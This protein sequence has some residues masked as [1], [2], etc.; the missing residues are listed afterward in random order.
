MY[1]VRCP[2]C[3]KSAIVP[4]AE[5]GLPAVCLACGS[6]YLIPSP[7]PAEPDS[8]P[9]A[10]RTTDDPFDNAGRRFGRTFWVAAACG[11]IVAGLAAVLA[12]RAIPDPVDRATAVRLKEEAETY[13]KE[14]RLAD[15]QRKYHELD[16][17]AGGRRIRDDEVRGLVEQA[18]DD[19]RRLYALLLNQVSRQQQARSGIPATTLPTAPPRQSPPMS[20]AVAEATPEVEEAAPQFESEEVA[21]SPPAAEE[22][23]LSPHTAGP[24]RGSDTS[25]TSPA[26]ST[27]L[28]SVPSENP[29]TAS[30]VAGRRAPIRPMPEQVAGVTDAEIGRSIEKGVEF[31]LSRFDGEKHQLSDA[32]LNSADGGGRNALAVYALMQA[33]QATDDPRLNPRGPLMDGLIKRMK[34]SRLNRGQPQVYATAIRATALALYNRRQDRGTLRADVL[35]LVQSHSRGAYTYAL[36]SRGG[37]QKLWFDNSNSQYGLLGVWAGAEANVEVPT[38]YWIAVDDHW[39]ETQLS[40]GQW[41]YGPG[42]D[43]RLSMTVAGLASLFVTHDRLDAHAAARV[44]GAQPYP[45]ELR[46]GLE[47]LERGDN[48]LD[49]GSSGHWGYTLYGIER[50]GLASGLKYFGRHDWYRVLAAQVVERQSDSGMWSMGAREDDVVETSFALLFLARGRHPILMNK[51]RF[52]GAWA[53]RPRDL[54]NLARFASRQLEREL[55]WQ[56]VPL[57][58][59]KNYADWLDSPI[60]YLASHEPP[61]LAEEDYNNLRAFV[62]AGGLLFTHADGDSAAFSRWVNSELSPKLFPQYEMDAIEP[63]HALWG[64][65]FKIDPKLRP[66]FRG[67]SNGSRLLMVHAPVDVARSWQMRDHSSRRAVFD[68][69]VNLFVYA[70]GKRDLRN[71]L[72]SPHVSD[73]GS[74]ARGA[75]RVARVK[76]PGQWDPEPGAWRRYAKWLARETGTGLDLRPVAIDALE[77][78][79]APIANLTGTVRHNF[80]PE[81]ADAIR[82]YV[83]GGGVLLIDETGGSGDFAEAVQETLL[84]KAFPNVTPVALDPRTHPLFRAGGEESGMSD[85][86]RPKLRPY[87]TERLSAEGRIDATRPLIGFAAGR[88]H[89]V[90]SPLDVTSGLLGTRT[91]GVNGLETDYTEALVKNL[92]F[93]TLDGQQDVTAQ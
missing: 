22:V 46:R 64:L 5:A 77:P 80:R 62:E 74:P 6:R 55:N 25:E 23:A 88:G 61:Q 93:W 72:Q 45:P 76:Y 63:D 73:P 36:G 78:G 19:Q 37:T 15:A 9:A 38:G 35:S 89:V 28:R 11:L 51:L 18:R 59:S 56:V 49:V 57:R 58:P 84:S 26:D 44:V 53:N 29:V 10:A 69:G 52:D 47:W 14:G 68:L 8:Q 71:R 67:V 86:S 92:V 90:F 85:L 43:G 50:V 48:A 1:K 75:V 42:S 24:D 31:L 91:W 12:S 66:Q 27:T 41:G 13:A 60:L 39:K 82:R 34:E 40:N 81:D 17:L 30:P 21:V 65:V 2:N 70:A 32:D 7:V 33:G 83:E 3:G 87:A 16:T 4:E 54:A 20:D 79:A